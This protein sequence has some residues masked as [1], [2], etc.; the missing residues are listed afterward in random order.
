MAKSGK[1]DSTTPAAPPRRD[2]GKSRRWVLL[3]L[4]S[5]WMFILGVLV[6]RGTSPVHFDTEALQ[7]ELAS[8]REAVLEK[9]KNRFRIFEGD[10]KKKTENLDFYE[11]LKKSAPEKAPA[12]EA[13]VPKPAPPKPTEQPEPAPKP[14]APGPVRLGTQ[15]VPAAAKPFT[16]QVA[17]L[18]DAR[19]ADALVEKLQAGGYPAYRE[20]AELSGK[21]TWHRVRIGSF[22]GPKDAAPTLE[23]LKKGGLQPMLIRK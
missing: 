13:P 10:T 4:V 3:L 19:T 9:E 17:S 18:K 2:R 1:T 20:Q 22:S 14:P 7:K 21:G 11:S 5:V 8:L 12:P 15:E 6:G 16:I 23:R